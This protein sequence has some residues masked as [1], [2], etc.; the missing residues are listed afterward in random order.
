MRAVLLLV[1]FSLLLPVAVAPALHAF[2]TGETREEAAVAAVGWR[3]LA[4]QGARPVAR[5]N[6]VLAFDPA[7]NRLYLHGGRGRSGTLADLWVFDLAA[8]TWT[9]LTAQGPKP[10]ARFGHSGAWDAKRG[11]LIVFAGQGNTGFFSDAWAFDPVANRWQR[12]AANDAGPSRRYGSCAGYDETGDR[13]LV[14][15][16]FTSTGRFDDTWALSL[17]SRR[18]TELTPEGSRPVKRCLHACDWDGATGA[19][20]L[21]GGQT[22][23]VPQLG[24]TWVL[25]REGWKQV[26]GRAPS[27]RRF[28]AGA[29]TGDGRFVING[30]IGAKTFGDTWIFDAKDR[31]WSRPAGLAAGPGPRH[32][33]AVASD[34][35]ADRLFVF[36]GAR[37]ARTANDLW[38]VQLPRR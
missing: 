19:L 13:I 12:L 32:S 17:A 27:A 18:W 11:R 31:K 16:G 28:P 6:A 37:P 3:Q 7:D 10:A 34:R 35:V 30:G 22:D 29:A 1:V 5:E 33:H 21:F 38:V 36:G 23:G 25:D 4:P 2:A 15:H 24:D 9:K 8:R 14:S 26:A 20:V